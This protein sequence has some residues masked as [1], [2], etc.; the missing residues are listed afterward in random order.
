MQ[1]VDYQ[2]GR[3]RSTNRFRIFVCGFTILSFFFPK[4]QFY[5]QFFFANRSA[6][7][8]L[9]HPKVYR[10]SSR[11][12]TEQF[13]IQATLIHTFSCLPFASCR[14]PSLRQKGGCKRSLLQFL[15]SRFQSS[16]AII[17][18]IIILVGAV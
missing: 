16:F 2:I 13:S 6:L 17:I 8:V 14:D 1:G 15:S 4:R 10:S 18:P 3:S 9:N 11:K 12:S 5:K 7:K